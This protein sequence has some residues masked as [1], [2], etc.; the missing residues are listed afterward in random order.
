MN[1]KKNLLF[2]SSHLPS[3]KVPQAGQKIAYQQLQNYA[4]QYNVYLVAFYNEIE[5][6]FANSNELDFCTQHH[7]FEV[8]ASSRMLAT[9]TNILLPL[10]ASVRANN[11]AR[12]LIIDL[13]SSVCFD[14]AHFEFTSAAY[15]LDTIS[16]SAHKIITEHDITFQSLERKK[17]ASKGLSRF[18]YNLEY[19]R[20]KEWELGSLAKAD[21]IIVL[22]DKDRLLLIREGVIDKKI[23]VCPPII[24]QKFRQVVRKNIEPHTI[25]FWGAMSRIENE[26]ALCFFINDILP[27][28]LQKYPDARLYVVGA[29][30]SKK[31]RD[32]SSPNVTVT[33]FVND[34]LEYFKKCQIAI[35]PLRMGAGIKIKVLEYLEAGLP[36][37]AT[38][39]GAE[40]IE[41]RN[42][43]VAD[44][45][46]NFA[47][48]VI[49]GLAAVPKNGVQ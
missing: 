15:Y 38:S 31:I 16:Q 7:L 40:G 4:V 45:A 24:D 17:S 30:P 34:P 6:E 43:V 25:L 32:K 41:H 36:V 21:E 20:Q 3:I 9:L 47:H 10:R 28:V 18:F 39:I 48:A 27:A 5:K 29:D 42:L 12:K 35:A 37:V 23:K 13:Q 19:I 49:L 1:N 22:C 11:E 46:A 33:G 14:V 44:G 26:D 8:S 2:I